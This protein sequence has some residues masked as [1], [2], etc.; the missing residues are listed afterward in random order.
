MKICIKIC[1]KYKN[2]ETKSRVKQKKEEK[3]RLFRLV[4]QK[5][6]ALFYEI[7]K[8]NKKAKNI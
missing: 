7:M 1:I 6:L 4:A 8:I 3:Y 2:I 5:E